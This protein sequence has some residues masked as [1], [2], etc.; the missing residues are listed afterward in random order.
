MV[1]RSFGA[2]DVGQ[3]VVAFFDRGSFDEVV[4]SIITE[5]KTNLLI[6]AV[7]RS[8]LG[9]RSFEQL[10]DG[11]MVARCE[12]GGLYKYPCSA[13]FIGTPEECSREWSSKMKGYLP[14]IT[15]VVDKVG[16]EITIPDYLNRQVMLLKDGGTGAILL[17]LDGVVVRSNGFVQLFP[18]PP[19]NM[20]Y[21]L[22]RE[23]SRI[24][25]HRYLPRTFKYVSAD[26]EEEPL[27]VELALL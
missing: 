3:V 21:I 14:Q 8:Q 26:A 11:E 9:L 6:P 12:G 17:T 18:R 20:T 15:Q 27:L 13:F 4:W 24:A 16:F 19:R 10:D 2:A 22:P 7:S 5:V 23:I 25:E 1:F